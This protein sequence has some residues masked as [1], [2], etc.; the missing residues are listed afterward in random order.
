[1]FKKNEIHRRSTVNSVSPV[2]PVVVVPTVH[3]N[4]RTT[5]QTPPSQA[6]FELEAIVKGNVV[7]LSKE[8]CDVIEHCNSRG[9]TENTFRVES[10]LLRTYLQLID[11]YPSLKEQQKWSRT[12]S[13]PCWM[14]DDKE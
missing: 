1:M 11:V 13:K 9:L 3:Y 10:I 2:S 4:E 7:E 6:E 14:D 8:I 12:N 5:D